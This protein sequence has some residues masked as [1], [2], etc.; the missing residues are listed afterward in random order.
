MWLDLIGNKLVIHWV[1]PINC[2]MPMTIAIRLCQIHLIDVANHDLWSYSTLHLS[3]LVSRHWNL[4][5]CPI[6]GRWIWNRLSR[7]VTKL[8]WRRRANLILLSWRRIVMQVVLTATSKAQTVWLSGVKGGLSLPCWWLLFDLGLRVDLW[9]QRQRLIVRSMARM[10][11]QRLIVMHVFFF[12]TIWVEK[13]P[14]GL[15]L[16]YSIVL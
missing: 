15:V 8:H 1:M 16:K 10:D 4:Q 7:C 6:N 11:L 9:G 2:W 12:G 3:R 13:N 5:I 14:L